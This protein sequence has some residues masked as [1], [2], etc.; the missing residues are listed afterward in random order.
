MQ[1]GVRVIVCPGPKPKR[2]FRHGSSASAVKGGLRFR[3]HK[4]ET[5]RGTGG[6]GSGSETDMEIGQLATRDGGT[7]PPAP[8]VRRNPGPA[9]IQLPSRTALQARERSNAD[10]LLLRRFSTPL[11]RA[12]SLKPEYPLLF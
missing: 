10:D 8:A 3:W 11:N 6:V 4:A 12:P 2:L 1:W 7:V 9:S 5:L